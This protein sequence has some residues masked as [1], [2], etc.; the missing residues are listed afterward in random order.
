MFILKSTHYRELREL[1]SRLLASEAMDNVLESSNPDLVDKSYLKQAHM[2]IQDLT[3]QVAFLQQKNSE[4]REEKNAALND[5][6]S[7]RREIAER[8]LKLM[9]D[10]FKVGQKFIYKEIPSVISDISI[11]GI[12]GMA[13]VHF[14]VSATSPLFSIALEDNYFGINKIE[15]L[16][17]LIDDYK[18]KKR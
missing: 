7:I 18:P 6:K 1:K 2:E 3:Q 12:D 15:Y 13:K 10:Q 17:A 5:L 8:D 11:S 16:K 9:L 14:D 4:L